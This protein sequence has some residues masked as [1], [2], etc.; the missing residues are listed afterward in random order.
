MTG[1]ENGSYGF[2]N[3]VILWVVFWG[4]KIGYE[5]Y[6]ELKQKYN[7]RKKSKGIL[8]DTK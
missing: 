6:Q 2:L 8:P 5:Y 3:L 1:I 7:E 4:V